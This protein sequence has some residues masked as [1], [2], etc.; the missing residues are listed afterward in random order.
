MGEHGAP[1][2]DLFRH[3]L[4]AVQDRTDFAARKPEIGLAPLLARL[5]IETERLRESGQ[6]QQKPYEERPSH[7]TT[8]LESFL[9]AFTS[10]FVAGTKEAA[11][12][13]RASSEKGNTSP[14]RTI[15]RR[16][17]TWVAVSTDGSSV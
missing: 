4:V 10:A 7:K 8:F 6:T 1:E 2:Q 17:A 16:T 12:P 11:A 9:N 5:E 14:F 15:N 13:P 3:V